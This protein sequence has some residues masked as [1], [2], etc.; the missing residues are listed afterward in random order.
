[1]V[2]SRVKECWAK[3]TTKLSQCRLR[4]LRRKMQRRF[5]ALAYVRPAWTR[6]KEGW[7]K[8][9][10]GCSAITIQSGD[11]QIAIIENWAFDEDSRTATVYHFRVHD[12]WVGKGMGEPL[13]RGFAS[14]VRRRYGVDTILFWET[15]QHV[16]GYTSLFAR[17]GATQGGVVPGGYQEWV[18][19]I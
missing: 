9:D 14:A 10:F 15:H 2:R 19:K 13:L 18:W 16:P 8:T 7:E 1:M 3:V 6:L 4:M 11:K 12:E 17:L 5:M